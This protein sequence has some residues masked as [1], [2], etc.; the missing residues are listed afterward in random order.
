MSSGQLTVELPHGLFD[1]DGT[2]HRVAVLRALAGHEELALAEN[3]EEGARAV[4]AWLAALVVRIGAFDA[5]EPALLDAL[6]RGDREVLLLAVRANL[7]GDRIGLVVRCANPACG[8]ASDI[9]VW[10]H[11]LIPPARPPAERIA[12]TTDAGT[13]YVREPTGADDIFVEELAGEHRDRAA[14][15][16]ARL[17][18]LGPEPMTPARWLAL[19][20]AARHAVALALAEH[21]RAPD[22][23]LVARCPACRALLELE[24]DPFGL[25]ARELRAG[26]ERIF[27]EVHAL[28]FH[29]H[30]SEDAILAL[31][32]PRRWKYLELLARELEGRPLVDRWS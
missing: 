9:D 29:Y 7:F 25:L 1:D 26:G 32:R 10:V 16:W 6:T 18:E 5:I 24:L 14:A 13:A 30:W 31:P 21:G 27:A 2:C 4:S 3:L 23:T 8:E 22:L 11:E 20:A 19:P 17:V 15:L 28:A 12:C